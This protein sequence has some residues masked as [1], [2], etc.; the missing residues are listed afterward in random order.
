MS[1]V[2]CQVSCVRCHMS[3]VTCQV[4][5]VRYHVSGVRCQ[6]SGVTC[7]VSCVRCQVSG[8]MCQV[9]R[10]RC[11]MSRDVYLFRQLNILRMPILS[12][13]VFSAYQYYNIP[14]FY[15]FYVQYSTHDSEKVVFFCQLANTVIN[16]IQQ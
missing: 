15:A 14:V 1:G 12:N 11:H 5:R 13:L 4:S 3:G 10:V 16:L 6:V 8:V 9:S 7:Q 2:R